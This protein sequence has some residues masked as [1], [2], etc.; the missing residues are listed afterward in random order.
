MGGWGVA[1]SDHVSNLEKLLTLEFRENLSETFDLFPVQRPIAFALRTHRTVVAISGFRDERGRVARQRRSGR[2]FH[3]RCGPRL[4]AGWR[5]ALG[6][7]PSE[8]LV[9]RLFHHD[10]V[11]IRDDD[12]LQ[13]RDLAV[14]GT[15]V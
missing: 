1:V 14:R 3:R 9:E 4:S 10:L 5:A 2:R 8:R 12:P 13:L 11:L 6:E 7:Q 15:K